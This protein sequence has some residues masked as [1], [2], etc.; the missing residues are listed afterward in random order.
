MTDSHNR[1]YYRRIGPEGQIFVRTSFMGDFVTARLITFTLMA[2]R[3]LV[4]PTTDSE[5][6]FPEE[7]LIRKIARK[8]PIDSMYFCIPARYRKA[9]GIDREVRFEFIRDDA[10]YIFPAD[11]D[12][13]AHG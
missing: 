6:E 2:D 7:K 5:L 4:T 1:T 10:F 13:I 11:K 8:T 12:G 9:V 3:I